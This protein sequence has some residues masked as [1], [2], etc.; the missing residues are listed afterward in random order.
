MRNLSSVLA[1]NEEIYLNTA[2]RILFLFFTLPG[3]FLQFK[4]INCCKKILNRNTLLDKNVWRFFGLFLWSNQVRSKMLVIE[5]CCR[6]VQH[7]EQRQ[8]VSSYWPKKAI[9]Q[10]KSTVYVCKSKTFT[11]K[12]WWPSVHDICSRNIKQHP[13]P[14]PT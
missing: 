7:R 12:I 3:M 10:G 1:R 14:N 13:K 4:L 2:I 11:D 9:I 6:F 8:I 5:C